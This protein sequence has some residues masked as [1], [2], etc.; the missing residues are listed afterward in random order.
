MA[1]G[2]LVRTN[3]VDE[4]RIREIA[5]DEVSK[6]LKPIHEWQLSFWSNG[7]GRPPGFFQMRVKADDER[8]D[9]MAL[10]QKKTVDSLGEVTDF[11]KNYRQRR[12][13]RERRWKFW[14]PIMKRVL[15]GAATVLITLAGWAFSRI[16][17]IV[18]IL[19]E[20]YLR[21]HPMVIQKMKT[22]SV[23]T[24]EPVYA[25]RQKPPQD[26][27]LPAEYQPR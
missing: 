9:R 21:A 23:N 5:M 4:E 25:G 26:A 3:K 19:W 20:D 2:G 15:I 18:K 13:E 7:S 24:S 11:V 10:E 17:P 22:I 16:E 6:Q 27:D 8:Y 12:E 1:V 14:A